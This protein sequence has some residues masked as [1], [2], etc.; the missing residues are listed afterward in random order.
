MGGPIW[1]GPL[2]DVP[3]INSVLECAEAMP[4]PLGTLA[5]INGML[6]VAK[7]VC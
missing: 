1:L 2:H 7:E 3:F 5:R 4:H 6:S